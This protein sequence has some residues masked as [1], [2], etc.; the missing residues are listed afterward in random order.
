V[1]PNVIEKKWLGVL[2]LDFKLR[3]NNVWDKEQ[4][5]KEAWLIWMIWHIVVVVN[6]WRGIANP[7]IPQG[8]LDCRDGSVETALHRFWECRSAHQT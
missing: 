5:S 6:E 7:M 3:W 1:V 4:V 2:P 8:C